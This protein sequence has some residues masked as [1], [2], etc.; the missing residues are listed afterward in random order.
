MSSERMHH[1]L[2]QL[3]RAARLPALGERSDADLLRLFIDHH[4]E[5]AFAALVRRHAA[6]V[7]GVCR[8][9]TGDAHDAEDAFQ[10]AFCVLLRKA[11]SIRRREVLGSWLYGVAYRTSLAAK[12]RRAKTRRRETQVDAMPQPLQS[13]SDPTHD[14]Q[15]LLDAALERLPE[16]YR[17][18]IVLCDLEGKSRRE[19]AQQLHLPE[20]TLSSRLARGRRLLAT[21][22][23]RQGLTLSGGA[24][25]SILTLQSAAASIPSALVQAVTQSGAQ[26]LLGQAPAA[27]AFSR[28]VLALTEGVMK[29]MLIGKLKSLT[30]LLIACSALTVGGLWLWEASAAQIG[31]APVRNAPAKPTGGA[32][33]AHAASLPNAPLNAAD[34]PMYSIELVVNQPDANGKMKAIAAPKVAVQLK[35]RIAV[36]QSG[37]LFSMQPQ[38]IVGDHL[39][40]HMQ[41]IHARGDHVLLAVSFEQKRRHNKTMVLG[42]SVEF[43][44]FVRLDHWVE[45]VDESRTGLSIKIKVSPLKLNVNALPT[46]AQT[47]TDPNRLNPFG[48]KPSSNDSRVELPAEAAPLELT[49]FKLQHMAASE[50]ATILKQLFSEPERRNMSIAV[51]NQTNS[52]LVRSSRKDQAGLAALLQK[53]DVSSAAPM[54]AADQRVSRLLELKHVNAKALQSMLHDAWQKPGLSTGVHGDDK[55]GMTLHVLAP[56]SDMNQIGDLVARLDMP[57]ASGNAATLSKA[58]QAINRQPDAA[59][60]PPAAVSPDGIRMAV[61]QKDDVYILDVKTG[62]TLSRTTGNDPVKS[63]AFSPDGKLIA[64]SSDKGNVQLYDAATGKLIRQIKS[65]QTIARIEFAIDGQTKVIVLVVTTTEP[66]VR[67]WDLNTGKLLRVEPNAVPQKGTSKATPVPQEGKIENIHPEDSNLVHISIGSDQGLKRDDALEIYR[68][69]PAPRYLGTMRIVDVTAQT[70][71]GRLLGNVKQPLRVGDRVTTSLDRNP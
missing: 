46:P 41:L 3:R 27:F 24:L 1:V 4:D 37:S 62:R 57:A 19:A 61:G 21:R 12:V 34:E 51:D 25:A 18:P 33:R 59:A 30:V 9:V 23:K 29:T 10:A 7:L 20:G 43:D 63:L 40:Y 13:P 55:K 67:V 36:Y 47:K 69:E 31:P 6:M 42:Q 58:L 48:V 17:A 35:E 26:L 54:P 39:A 49:V 2:Q 8:R 44:D 50:A 45:I 52:L 70:A 11:S 14:W 32:S 65:D 56:A 38:P 28:S 60:P 68:L 15:P 53:L 22:L 5:G 64:S 71:V 66:A 16:T